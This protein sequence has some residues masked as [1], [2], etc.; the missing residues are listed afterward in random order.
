MSAEDEDELLRE[1]LEAAERMAEEI[2]RKPE[3]VVD[4]PLLVHLADAADA[5]GFN[6]FASRDFYER[7]DPEAGGPLSDGH[8]VRAVMFHEHT[9]GGLSV[10]H[11]RTCIQFE[12]IDGGMD[13]MLLDMTEAD[14]D[15]LPN[16]EFPEPR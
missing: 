6:A 1:A 4:T 15:S 10:P 13:E 7:V 9:E 2:A 14:F 5:R 12:C 3:K 11:V 8:L 16:Y